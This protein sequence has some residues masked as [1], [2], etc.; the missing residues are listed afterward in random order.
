VSDAS[1]QIVIFYAP[2][3]GERDLDKRLTSLS[4]LIGARPRPTY[5]SKTQELVH[6]TMFRDEQLENFRKLA[7]A[8]DEE[9]HLVLIG[10]GTQH[11]YSYAF[12]SKINQP[13]VY[14]VIDKHS[15]NEPN[16]FDK[17]QF[18][19]C[20]SYVYQSVRDYEN[21]QRAIILGADEMR[22][23]PGFN[24]DSL[25]VVE[26]YAPKKMMITQEKKGFD[27][28]MLMDNDA[29]VELKNTI[30]K[31]RFRWKTL[32]EFD[33]SSLDYPA[34]LSVDLDVL[35]NISYDRLLGLIEETK[36][37]GIIGSDICNL[38]YVDNFQLAE[39]VTVLS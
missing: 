32:D 30:T 23:F 36:K 12:L 15:D 22:W 17:A 4:D 26:L 10:S 14:V 34:Y 13:F 39:L 11:H 5:N 28:S 38:T 31:Y 37:H 25:D 20:G 3:S 29:I 9:K 1:K 7:D 16:R 8:I 19:W 6:S 33:F 27:E 24:L 35:E 21:A 2:G 18:M